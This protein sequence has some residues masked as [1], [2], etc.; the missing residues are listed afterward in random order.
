MIAY[1]AVLEAPEQ[2]GCYTR[3]A[4]RALAGLPPALFD[5]DSRSE[6][7]RALARAVQSCSDHETRAMAV[8]ALLVLAVCGRKFF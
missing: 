2:A 4:A 8:A 7:Q 3:G 5:D 6:S 1:C